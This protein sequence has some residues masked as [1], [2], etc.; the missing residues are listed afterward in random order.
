MT[1]PNCPTHATPMNVGQKGGFYCPKKM[2]D[3]TYC[4][5]RIAAPAPQGNA[6]AAAVAAP[7]AT[8]DATIACGAF[9]M[10]AG[11]YSG[12]IH[13]ADI[14]AQNAVIAFAV[15]AYSAMKTVMP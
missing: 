7:A 4:K 10:A 14:E 5:E 1:T 8:S 6:A 11:V 13:S 15:R 3:G 2:P 12:Q 9:Q